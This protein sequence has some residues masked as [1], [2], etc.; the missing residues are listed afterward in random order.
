MKNSKQSTK[1]SS[2]THTRLHPQPHSWWKE[3]EEHSV[4]VLDKQPCQIFARAG[5]DHK[6]TTAIE[7][8]K[9]QKTIV[10][11]DLV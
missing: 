7:T 5:K 9:L 8:G 10:W 1:C 11:I 6:N 3:E 4:H 2:N